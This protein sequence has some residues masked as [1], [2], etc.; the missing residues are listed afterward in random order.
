MQD[1]P[2]LTSNKLLIAFPHQQL[3]DDEPDKLSNRVFRFDPVWD[4]WTECAG[5]RYS[6]YRCG[7]AVLKEEIYILGETKTQRV[8]VIPVFRLRRAHPAFVHLPG[9]I[10]C[11]G[12]DRGQSRYCLSSVEIYN[13]DTDTW[14][15]GP[16]LPTSLLTLR[17]N[18]S[19]A[20]VVGDKLY[21]C[22]FFKGAGKF[23]DSNFTFVVLT[24]LQFESKSEANK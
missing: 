14:R 6:R 5:M 17:T 7:V 8:D 23:I 9:G 20:G 18:A 21:L 10:G 19:N 12:Q 1:F 13:P 2:C 3:P 22:G 15:E 16:S 11:D 24:G 4:R